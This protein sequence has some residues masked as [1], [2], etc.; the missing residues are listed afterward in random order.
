MINV[1]LLSTTFV[2]KDINRKT[3]VEITLLLLTR[4]I[5]LLR[6]IHKRLRVVSDII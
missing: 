5:T 3:S 6:C 2:L 1:E 4:F